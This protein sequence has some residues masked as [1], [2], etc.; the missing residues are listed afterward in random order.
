[1]KNLSVKY[2]V[3]FEIILFVT[4][5][6]FSG[7]LV[8]ILELFG[9]DSS[10]SSS[11]ARILTSMI[12]LIAFRKVFKFKNA[13]KGFVIMLPTL[14]LAF[15][16]IPYHFVS[17]GGEM[18]KLS[19]SIILIALAPAIFEEILF[20]GIF[21]YYLKQKYDRSI[22][23]V[24][25]SAVLFSVVHLTNIAAMDKASLFFQLI[26]AFV[27]GVTWAAV[28]ICTEDIV[29][30]IIAHFLVDILSH[31][32]GGGT[33]S[34]ICILVIIIVLFMIEMIYGLALVRNE[35]QFRR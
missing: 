24:I 13:F 29:S 30:L 11:I 33:T 10:I 17:D 31:L 16:K 18:N 22:V 2:P 7:L 34:S 25:L 4:V 23:V 28:Y 26:M 27:L 15:Y 1:M 12:L 9:C 35:I 6:L 32:F 5:I 8:G 14:L 3:I 19:C 20:R 21:I